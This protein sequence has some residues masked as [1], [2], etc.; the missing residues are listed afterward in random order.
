MSDEPEVGDELNA[1]D[2]EASLVSAAEKREMISGRSSRQRDFNDLSG[3]EL[4]NAGVD[5]DNEVI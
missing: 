1:P 3:L 4:T 2:D 5:F